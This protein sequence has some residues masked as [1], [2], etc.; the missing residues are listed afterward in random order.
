MAEFP[1]K[2]KVVVVGLGGIVECEVDTVISTGPEC[3]F[4]GAFS[5][6]F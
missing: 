4:T 5:P 2:A 6:S 1:T 3:P